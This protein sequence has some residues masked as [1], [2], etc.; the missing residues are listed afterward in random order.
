MRFLYGLLIVSVLF[1]NVELMAAPIRY[2][3]DTGSSRIEF[4]AKSTLHGIHGKAGAI[5]PASVVYDEDLSD[6][7]LSS[8]LEVSVASLSTENGRRDK[9]MKQMFDI[10]KLPAIRWQA[11]SISCSEWKDNQRSCFEQGALSIHGITKDI[12]VP[13]RLIHESKSLRSV[14][15]FPIRLSDFNLKPPSVFGMIKVADDMKV[16]FDLVWVSGNE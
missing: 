15:E 11:R 8:D 16:I 4:D 7:A 14:G 2:T 6:A 13:L 5:S 1:C 10:N 3:L 12:R 9:A